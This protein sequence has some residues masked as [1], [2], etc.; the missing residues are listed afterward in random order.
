MTQEEL[1]KHQEE[2]FLSFYPFCQLRKNINPNCRIN[3]FVHLSQPT[4]VYISSILMIPENIK[5]LSRLMSVT[6]SSPQDL[7]KDGWEVIE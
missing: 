7:V 1:L 5:D 3:G 2:W 6:Y 4:K